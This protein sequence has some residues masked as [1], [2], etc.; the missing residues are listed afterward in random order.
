V[1]GVLEEEAG[2]EFVDGVGGVVEELLRLGRHGSVCFYGVLASLRS[3]ACG[4]EACS[5]FNQ[6]K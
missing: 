2:D 6:L 5:L 3:A 1:V 4:L